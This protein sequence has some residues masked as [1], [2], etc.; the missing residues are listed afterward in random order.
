MLKIL[1]NIDRSQDY[2]VNELGFEV[3]CDNYE[4]FRQFIVD[5][6]KKDYDKFYKYLV[7]NNKLINEITIIGADK[8]YYF[9]I[10][11]LRHKNYNMNIQYKYSISRSH[12]IRINILSNVAEL[13][14]YDNYF[15]LFI[16]NNGSS[17]ATTY[18]DFE[19]FYE[20]FQNINMNHRLILGDVSYIDNIFYEMNYKII[21][22]L[23]QV[24]Y[25]ILMTIFNKP[26]MKSANNKYS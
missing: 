9:N 26:K 8:Q 6:S 18:N 21:N 25:K 16:D 13:I 20:N 12:I 4:E 3:V 15:I 14:F 5:N 1:D 7:D 24:L 23:D 11:N 10:K 19:N 17:F 22:K 2:L